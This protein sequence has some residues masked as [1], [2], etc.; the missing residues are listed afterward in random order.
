MQIL[1]LHFYIIEIEM[2]ILY[3]VDFTIKKAHAMFLH[4]KVNKYLI[5][6]IFVTSFISIEN[7]SHDPNYIICQSIF[8]PYWHG[9]PTMP[10][11]SLTLA[12]LTVPVEFMP[13]I[14]AN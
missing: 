2:Q 3:Y 7:D 13:L 4:S 5:V 14:K 10:D 9:T 11:K 12:P 1:K 8:Q 6:T